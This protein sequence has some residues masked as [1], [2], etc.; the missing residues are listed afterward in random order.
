MTQ[1]RKDRQYAYSVALSFYNAKLRDNPTLRRGCADRHVLDDT[2]D[3]WKAEE[4]LDGRVIKGV[5]R[6]DII[7]GL[8]VKWKLID[9]KLTEENI[10]VWSHDDVDEGNDEDR[11]PEAIFVDDKASR[12]ARTVARIRSSRL[13]LESNRNGMI[14]DNIDLGSGAGC[15]GNIC[16]I[17]SAVTQQVHIRNE[18]DSDVYCTVKG[19]AAMQRGINIDGDSHFEL[20]AGSSNFINVSYVPKMMGITKSIVVFDF[21]PINFDEEDSID[22]FSI[23]R[24][25]S[26]RAGD[27]D[28][29][30]ILK[31][32]APYIKK[33]QRRDDGGKFSNP[34]RIKGPLGPMVPFVN[35]LGWFPVPGEAERLAANEKEATRK[36]D[37][38]FRGKSS[39]YDE[40]EKVDYPSCLTIDNYAKCMQY[41]L[42]MEE[43]QMKVD[44]KS[45]DLFDSPLM[46]EGRSYYKLL[47]PGLAENRP[48]VLKGDKI[49]IH[50][51]GGAE[52]EGLVHRTTQ[53]YAIMDLPR[54][55]TR[56]YIDG[57]RVDVRFTFSRT[58]LRTSHQAL[59]V[60]GYMHENNSSIPNR[61]LFPKD[62][63]PSSALNT[64]IIQASQLK[65]FNRTLN[66]EQQDAVVGIVQAVARPAPYLIYGPPGTGKTVTLVESIL[67]TLNATGSD[68]KAKILVAA[69]SNAAVDVV[70]ERLSPF[71]T[72]L[73]MLRLVAFSRDKASIPDGIFEYT[74]FVE[75]HNC[76]M[77]PDLATIRGVKIVAVTISYGGKLPNQG[78]V[79]HFT[80]VFIDEAGHS[81]ESE[82]IGCLASVT[83]QNPMQ[84]PFTVLAGDPKQLGP[85]IRSDI[86]KKFGLEKSLLERL[87]QM[88]PY[89]RSEET[90][91]LG[92]HYDTRMITKLVHNYRSHPKILCIPNKLF[93]E[94]DLIAEADITRSHRFVDWEHLPTRGFP[95]VFHGIEGEDMREANSPSWFNAEEAQI[96]KMYVDLLIKDTRRNRCKPEDIGIITPYH[97]Q[98][99]KI[100]MLLSAHGYSDC[101]VGSVEEFQGSERPVIIISTVRST[102]EYISFDIK[103]KLGFLSN[104]KRFNVAITRAQ[105]LL[106]MIGNPF[107]LE[108]D[109]N[110]R[111]IIDH[112]L[113]GGGYTGVEY[114]KKG[115]RNDSR[116]AIE[117]V[118][119]GFQAT[120][121]QDEKSDDDDDD[122]FVLV[123]HVTAQEGPAWRS[124]E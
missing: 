122:E 71:V 108:N 103:H 30:A 18:S 112:A 62:G 70:V 113:D 114:T 8:R 60:T 61:M 97:R 41:L 57:L 92:N 95:V 72:P 36:I 47:V 22:A 19:G 27:P 15:E 75:E 96:V 116:S 98:V 51:R 121:I 82:A 65:F 17:G 6:S 24:Y 9:S 111:S 14:I 102:V 117:D 56:A 86:C 48:S 118:I 43:V 69:P 26:I 1:R 63:P 66:Q 54:S 81:I 123:S 13:E 3:Q 11:M 74:N 124:E 83:K 59:M 94:G 67:Q 20:R 35:T 80:H 93:Y 79:D 34:V 115:Q 58:T 37:K 119:R 45:Y 68:P 105:A 29:Y 109:P 38:M 99:Q 7:F 77:M 87:S 55:F 85:I 100:R 46:R 40:R 49:L 76:F 4:R 32:T 2:I 64:R 101:K 25:I 31:P 5:P 89:A 39:Y 44:I 88:E 107:T 104:E 16:R 50:V 120:S 53:E 21:S 73:E 10:I 52:F 106:I 91:V 28:D 110:W 78:I 33:W 42:W 23:A 12:V 90:D 84:P